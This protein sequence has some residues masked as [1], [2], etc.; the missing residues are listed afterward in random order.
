MEMKDLF[1]KIID[2]NDDDHSVF[3]TNV[4]QSIELNR[5]GKLMPYIVHFKTIANESHNMDVGQTNATFALDVSL[6][7]TP[8][9][10]QKQ[11]VVE[12]LKSGHTKVFLWCESLDGIE[13]DLTG[14]GFLYSVCGVVD[15]KYA[16]KD[17]S[18][19]NLNIGKA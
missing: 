18:P 5:E 10:E 9:H 8:V 14:S 16:E 2:E 3:N 13:N 17:T 15:A 19:L 11:N 4:I 1:G 7:M 12:G 6:V